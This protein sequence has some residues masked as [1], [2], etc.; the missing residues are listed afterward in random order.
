MKKHLPLIVFIPLTILAVVGIL[1]SFMEWKGFTKPEGAAI[2]AGLL[3]FSIV[4]WQGYLIRRQME[5]Q[6]VI[7]LDKEWNSKEMLKKRSEAWLPNWNPNEQTIEA[8]LE[9][10]EKVSTL[11]RT[12]F[13]SDKLIWDTFGWYVMRYHRYTSALIP[14]L[15]KKWAMTNR[16]DP[17]LYCDLETLADKLLKREVRT[18]NKLVCSEQTKLTKSDLNSEMDSSKKE[19]IQLEWGKSSPGKDNCPQKRK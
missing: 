4:W 10:L 15:R 5:L 18:R 1:F 2:F 17:T 7:E 3:A 6:A 8:V 12:G 14:E 9:F 11:E 19:F 13:I 16:P